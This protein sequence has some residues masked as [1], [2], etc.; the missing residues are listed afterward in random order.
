MARGDDGVATYSSRGPVGD[1][2]VPSTW[3]IKPDLVA[4]GNAHCGRRSTWQLPL[5]Q[6][7]RPPGHWRKRRHVSDAFRFEHGR[8]RWSPEL[9]LSSSRR[10]RSLTPAAVSSLCRYSAE[11]LEGFGL[12]EQGAG[13]LNVPLA[14]AVAETLASGEGLDAAPSAVSIDGVMA[15]AGG[16][17]FMPKGDDDNVSPNVWGNTIIWGNRGGGVGGNTIIWGNRGGGV[18]GNT[19]IWGNARRRGGNTIIWGN[20]DGGVGGNTIIWGNRGRRG[21]NTIIWGNRGGGVGGNTIIWGNRGGGVGG[22]TIIW[23]NRGRRGGNTII[24]G[25]RRRR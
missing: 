11:P 3:E 25:N 12:I 14:V 7:P 5:G 1:P 20:R 6:L 16:L 18:G 4:P 15:E 23:G 17:A 9:S 8:R 24:W 19:I 21:G 2:D 22:N 13:S 10:S